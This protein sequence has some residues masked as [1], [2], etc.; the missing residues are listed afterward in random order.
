MPMFALVA[1][2]ACVSHAKQVAKAAT[3][4]VKA[5]LAQIDPTVARTLGDQAA[6]G[7]VTGAL[8]ALESEQHRELLGSFVETTSR[9]AARG[10]TYALS[11][12]S[13]RVQQLVDRTVANAVSGFGRRLAE[14]P[15]LR[16]QLAAITHQLSSSAVHGA[17]DA[18]ADIFPECSGVS[19]RR[20]CIEDVVGEVSRVAARGMMTG[21]I[22]AAKWP[23]LAL[24]FLAGV[25]VTL[26]FV[27]ARFAVT[28]GKALPPKHAH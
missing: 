23:I 18:L 4:G 14:D 11:T 26:L 21:F 2:V 15:T 27:R 7:V 12:E 1:A 16:G 9:A 8:A 17:R 5:Q 13:V 22:G 10:F 6:R 24:A 19:D 3:K 25:L 28:N 20:R